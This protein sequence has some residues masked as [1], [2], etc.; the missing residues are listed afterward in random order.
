MQ[1]SHSKVEQFEKC[2][3]KYKMR[4]IDGIETDAPINSDNA[5]VLGTALH[6]GIEKDVETAIEQYFMSYPIIDDTHVNEAI[7]LEHLIPKAKAVLPS[8]EYEVEIKDEDFHGFIDL[9]TP[10]T[11][12][13]RGVELPNVYDIYDFKYSNNANH[14]KDSRQLHLYKYFFEKCNPG[15]KIRNLYFLFVPKVNI[16]QKKTEDLQQFR[17]RLKAELAEADVKPVQIE[18]D[19]NKVIDFLLMVKKINEK[20]DFEQNQGWF[21]RYCEFEE[22]CMKGWNYFMKLPSTERRNIEKVEKRV[23]WIYGV[24]FCGKTT[25]AN[26]FPDPLMLNT[27]GNIK[28]VDAPYIRIK[29]EIVVEGRMTKKTLAWQIFKDVI[30]ELEKKENAFKTIIV[31]LVEDLYE[32]CRLFMYDQMGI[33]HESD[34]SFKAWDMVR[35]EFLNTLKRLMALDY[36]N[37]ILISHEDTSK[38][39]TKKGGD[40][41]TA[42]KPNMQDK[43]A[44]KVA[45]MVDI[46]ARI[47][48]D[49]DVRTFNFKSNEVIFGGGRLKT[50]A[51]DI[52]LDVDALF[53]VYDEANRNAIRKAQG[54]VSDVGGTNTPVTEETTTEGTQAVRRGRRK[55][56][57]DETPVEVTGNDSVDSDDTDDTAAD[58]GAVETPVE[59]PKP[60]TR[61]TRRTTENN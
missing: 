4:Y 2:P 6:T 22:Y 15:K 18:F 28:F 42:I 39:I 27:D 38:D 29:D 35:G 57:D 33:K 10:A 53:K 13:E 48:A 52:P 30:A 55:T 11:V 60:R 32:Y 56:S 45:G 58:T 37:I 59:E 25:F 36:E 50:D 1:W 24:P 19:F 8:G 17:Q 3:F 46:V 16:K 7:K 47:V 40:K 12:F 61:K 20:S 9:L 49:G 44:L 5:L 34:D 51:K 54:G 31:D 21:C 43:V 23:M 14:Y 41:I 26:A